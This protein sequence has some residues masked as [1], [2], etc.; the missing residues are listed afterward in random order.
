MND[1]FNPHGTTIV[2]V[3]RNGVVAIGGAPGS[4]YGRASQA[5]L[6]PEYIDM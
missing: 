5:R 2:G 6:A 1:S 4:S 3:R